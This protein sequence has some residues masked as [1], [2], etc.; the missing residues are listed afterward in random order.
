MVEERVNV[1]L[2]YSGGMIAAHIVEI[3]GI[4]GGNARDVYNLT[5]NGLSRGREHDR[6]KNNNRNEKYGMLYWPPIAAH[7]LR[8]CHWGET[9]FQLRMNAPPF[10]GDSRAQRTG[11]EV[12]CSIDVTN[13]QADLL[14]GWSL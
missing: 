2:V 12:I 14:N 13:R 9:S 7:A 1:I 4:R 10:G 5:R 3:K 8:V 6:Q 11:N